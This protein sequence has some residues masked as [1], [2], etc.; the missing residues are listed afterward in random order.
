ME[1]WIP[2]DRITFPYAIMLTSGL[3]DHRPPRQ[4]K[5]PPIYGEYLEK[6]LRTL[7][8]RIAIATPRSLTTNPH[9][10]TSLRNG[11]E[12]AETTSPT[13]SDLHPSLTVLDH[14]QTFVNVRRGIHFPG[15]TDWAGLIAL[16]ERQKNLHKDE[17]QY[18]RDLKSTLDFKFALC[19]LP[20]Q[21]RYLQQAKWITCDTAFKRVKGWKEF[22]IEAWDTQTNR[23]K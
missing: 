14:V 19:M 9:I 1:T 7:D 12:W 11:L 15:G 3:H 21:S 2:Y 10:A 18:I 8:W 17:H 22:G 20:A 13:L 4:T 16:Q 5:T 6:F 23:C